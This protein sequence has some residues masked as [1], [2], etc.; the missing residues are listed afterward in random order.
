MQRVNWPGLKQLHLGIILPQGQRLNKK[1]PESPVPDSLS[2]QSLTLLLL[3]HFYF[4][5]IY[6]FAHTNKTINYSLNFFTISAVKIRAKFLIHCPTAVNIAS[7]PTVGMYIYKHILHSLNLLLLENKTTKMLSKQT[8]FFL[9]RK[10]YQNR[11]GIH[12]PKVEFIPF[13]TLSI[14]DATACLGKTVITL[15]R[16]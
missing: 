13:L 7:Q 12:A 14:R 2:N 11:T 10:K 8:I 6:H 4:K 16:L 5:I 1:F 15:R 9:E 3:T